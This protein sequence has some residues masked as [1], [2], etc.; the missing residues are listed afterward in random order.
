MD[1]DN[2]SEQCQ[3]TEA[4]LDKRCEHTERDLSLSL[5]NLREE[6][7]GYGRVVVTA[8]INYRKVSQRLMP[9]PQLIVLSIHNNLD[10]DK[11]DQLEAEAETSC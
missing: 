9:M 2:A 7:A 8:S 3:E 5:H 11:K 4:W 6:T 1:R 10:W